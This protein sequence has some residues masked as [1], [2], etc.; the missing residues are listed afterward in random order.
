MGLVGKR[1]ENCIYFKGLI[2]RCQ[3]LNVTAGLFP[4]PLDQT[5]LFP[6]ISFLRFP[7]QGIRPIR[8]E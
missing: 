5:D 2:W 1:H 8:F 6:R 4:Q 7:G 3:A